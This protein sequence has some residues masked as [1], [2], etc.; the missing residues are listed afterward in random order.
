MAKIVIPKGAKEPVKLR[1]KQLA[2]GNKSFYLDIYSNGKR[3]YEFLG[4]YLIPE[5]TPLD[6][7]QNRQTV[8]L[9]NQIKAQRILELA[10]IKAGVQEPD[11]KGKIL[12]LDFLEY[13]YSEKEKQ[14]ITWLRQYRNAIDHIRNYITNYTEGDLPVKKIDA[15]WCKEFINYLRHIYRTAQGRALTDNTVNNYYVILSDALNYAVRKNCMAVNPLDSL[16]KGEK[17]KKPESQIAYLTTEE[18]KKLEATECKNPYVKQAYLFSCYCGLR[19]SDVKRLTWANIETTTDGLRLAITQ[20][21]TKDPLY[22]KLSEKAS[23]LLPDKEDS[24]GTDLVFSKLPDISNIDKTLKKW[25][26]SV[27]INK[28][29]TFHTARHTF[30]TLLITLGVDIYTVSQL[31]GHKDVTTTQIYAK[32][33]DKKKDDAVNLLNNL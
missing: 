13:F 19:I 16:E 21:K 25:A 1:L 12:F 4:Q 15:D 24:E 8:N 7:V 22:I 28:K 33:I 23:A 30:A 14:H 2:N 26:A 3:K 27:G 31:L 32:V 6:K 18:L 10:S 29:I 9:V 20:K 5:R 11:K 17:P